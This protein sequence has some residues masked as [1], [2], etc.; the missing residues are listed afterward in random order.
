MATSSAGVKLTAEGKVMLTPWGEEVKLTPQGNVPT[1]KAYKN[2]DFLGSPIAR[3]I[4]IMCE[5]YEPMK[6]LDEYG[7][8]NYFCFV[9]SHMVMHP[10]DRRKHIADLEALIK[11]GGDE[12]EVAGLLAKLAFTKKVMGMDKYYVMAMELAEKLGNWNKDR[13]SKGRSSYH[14]CTG[15][16]P[17]IMEAAN[18]GAAS[19]DELTL[20]FATTRPEWKRLN[21][22]VSEEGAF[23]FH[24]FFMRKFWMAYKCMGLVVLPG[25]YG[26]MDELFELLSLLSSKK[27]QHRLPIIL[28]GKEHWKKAIN[29]EYLVE[30]GML[31]EEHLKLITFADTVEE[32]F[33]ILVEQVHQSDTTGETEL[34]QKTK[35]RR[36]EK[37]PTNPDKTKPLA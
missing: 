7:V 25:G 34:I 24:Y 20:G 4:R 5:L 2:P 12:E 22:Y 29:F 31:A 10:D 21:K 35:R 17:G 27:I 32:A 23:E 13:V 33:E 14:V 6:R 3:H 28:L 15:G 8:D 36:L 1:I 30:C 26:S 11:V 16:G 18:R 19:T 9:G 37:H